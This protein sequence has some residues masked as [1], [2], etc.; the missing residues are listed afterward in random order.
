MKKDLAATKCGHVFHRSCIAQAL[1]T[2]PKCP[3]DRKPCSPSALTPLS[4]LV[5]DTNKQELSS[6]LSDVV[7]LMHGLEISNSKSEE[8]KF[9]HSADN[10]NADATKQRYE[11]Q[12]KVA[13]KHKN[14]MQARDAVK[15][16]AQNGNG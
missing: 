4:F 11:L 14:L 9:Q 5:T 15:A 6:K 3:L 12:T 7:A 16:V 1:A 10:E 13:L 2:K 8:V